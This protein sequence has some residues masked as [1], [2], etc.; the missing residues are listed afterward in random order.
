MKFNN[1]FYENEELSYEDVFLFQNYYSWKSRFDIDITPTIDLWMWIPMISANMNAV[2]WK[3]MSETLARY[4]WLWVLPQDM[5]LDT[6]IRIVKYIKDANIQYDTPITV[7]AENTIRDVMWIINKRAH[8]CVVM[9][10][11]QGKAKSIF[12]PKDFV[13]LDQFSLLWNLNQKPLITGNIWISNE[14]AFEI[15]DSNKIS[16]LPIIDKEWYLKWILTKK[17]TIRNTIYKPTLDKNWK[18]NVAVALWINN[19]LDK[20]KALYEI[21]VDIFVLD[22]AHWF[23][24]KMIESVKL[25]RKTFDKNVT[26]IAWNVCVE[27]WVKALLEAWAN[28]VKVWIWPWWMCT[29]RI[30]TGVWR[31]QFTAVYKCAKIAKE[32]WW[33]IWA[34][35]WIK[36]PRDMAL[37]LAAWANQCMMW[38]ILAWTLESTGDIKYDTEWLIYKE[39]YWM[40]SKKA[41]IFRNSKKSKFELTKRQ[42]FREWI[43]T[44]K[45]Y[46]KPWLESIG[47]FVDEYMTW[48]RSSMTYVW[49][50]NL[51]EF[52]EKSIVWVQTWAGY[53]EWT[54]H[55]K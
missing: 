2:T 20:A 47:D 41:V 24:S 30:K 36:H 1:S 42:L 25:F 44:S 37:A 26:L 10:D 27:D 38:T 46:L 35:G 21:W 50:M 4:G 49:A 7:K 43:S 18:L 34:D 13:D 19:F 28:W 29:T 6:M 5:S 39:S 15:M 52:E 33:F 11:N 31:P 45:R 23:Q 9:I 3:R 55:G 14:K 51:S 22:T 40:A 16:S 53:I 48:L 17:D 8:N 12:T 54:P 32:L